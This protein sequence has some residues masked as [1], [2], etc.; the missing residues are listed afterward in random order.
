M[1]TL[2][3]RWALVCAAACAAASL[4]ALARLVAG[5]CAMRQLLRSA[6][7]LPTNDV[8]GYADLLEL[9]SRGCVR[10]LASED[11]DAPVAVGWMRPAIVLPRALLLI[12]SM[13]EVRQVLR[14]ELEH[15]ARR[16]DWASLVFACIRCLFPLLPALVWFEYQLRVAR[17][18]ACDDAVLRVARPHAYAANLARIAEISCH[19]RTPSLL[20]NL[21]SQPSQLAR[22][23]DHILTDR[24]R[25]GRYGRV[26]L[27]LASSMIVFI[28]GV[29]VS[30][31]ALVGFRAGGPS[32]DRAQVQAP[33]AIRPATPA[34]MN[35]T[36]TPASLQ[37]RVKPRVRSAQHAVAHRNRVRAHLLLEPA[38][39]PSSEA[40]L[41]ICNDRGHVWYTALT[42]TFQ[43]EA[44]RS[45]VTQ[46]ELF[47]QEI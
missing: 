38:A 42:V 9:R 2:D 36:L 45:Q 1:W 11:I 43:T 34:G 4:W 25:S 19:H 14:H 21:L 37:V 18:M 13:D 6:A 15:L 3:Y 33:P 29:L 24:H 44:R 30:S 32:A 40:L 7:E 8:A 16:D 12:M 28:A 5:L 46:Q 20:P 27:V 41:V 26:Q 10:L 47:F 23:I 35:A 17:E 31:P 39:A 22:R